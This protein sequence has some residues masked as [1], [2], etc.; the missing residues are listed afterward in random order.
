MVYVSS[1]ATDYS[2]NERD[3][4]KFPLASLANKKLIIRQFNLMIFYL[5]AFINL[6][7]KVVSVP[8]SL[9][10]DDTINIY[11]LIFM[12][13]IRIVRIDEQWPGC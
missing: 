4:S 13:N 6:G 10:S 9:K 3:F 1:C 5:I 8:I 12:K 7:T 11:A 2:G